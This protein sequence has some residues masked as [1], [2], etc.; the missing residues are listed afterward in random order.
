MAIADAMSELP[1]RLSM[2]AIGRLADLLALRGQAVLC[3]HGV[4][5]EKTRILPH[6]GM[7]V[8][9]DFLTSLILDLK[10]R[11]IA[12]VSV[13]EALTRLRAG[14]PKPFVAFTLDDGYRD[15][16]EVAYPVF[17]AHDVPFT[18]FLTTG[19]LDRTHPMWWHV[20]E[21]VVCVN[22]RVDFLGACH[23]TSSLRDKALVL[24]RL[25]ALFRQMT[26]SQVRDATEDLVASNP[27]DLAR[28]AAYDF[29]LDW[30]MV[31][32]MAASGLGAFG[33]HTMTHP[34][35]SRLSADEA[36]TEIAGCRSRILE[37]SGV[38]ASLF[39]YPF[40]QPHEVGA[41]AAALVAEA[42]F[43]TAFSTESR[44]LRATDLDR[45][46]HLPRI[47]IVNK[48]QSSSIVRAYMSGI[49]SALKD[50]RARLRLPKVG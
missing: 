43:S 13:A 20:L 8:S 2:T 21:H 23:E 49:P 41:H 28:E 36:R 3:L 5:N 11:R 45:P 26:P 4:T 38:S 47:M 12:C 29:A 46:L 14:S 25:D 9:A 39:A 33:G 27:S 30:G 50:G 16:Y 42:G 18:I 1:F 32:E 48:A 7:S 22:D 6:G 15:N 31:R 19:L 40:G 17:R 10:A 37:A 44:V 24:R 34:L 35:L